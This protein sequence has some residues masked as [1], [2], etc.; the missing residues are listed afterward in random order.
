MSLL[1][2]VTMLAQP[3]ARTPEAEAAAKAAAD[4]AEKAKAEAKAKAATEATEKA[5]AEKAAA[6]KAAAEKADEAEKAKK[7]DEAEAAEKA[8]KADE[9]EK[10]KKADEAEK[11]ATEAEAKAAADEAEKAEKAKK[12]ATEA[13]AK[14]AADAAEKEAAEKA[15]AEA[16][17]AEAKA[18]AEKAAKAGEGLK[19]PEGLKNDGQTCYANSVIQLLRRM[20]GVGTK[21]D[22]DDPITET[23]MNGLVKSAL[24]TGTGGQQDAG[25]FFSGLVREEY[26]DSSFFQFTITQYKYEHVEVTFATIESTKPKIIPSESRTQKE[27]K[28]TCTEHENSLSAVANSYNNG[29]QVVTDLTPLLEGGYR[30]ED[31]DK[32][33]IGIIYISE[34]ARYIIVD[35]I[36]PWKH[37]T[38]TV[39]AS[40]AFEYEPNIKANGEILLKNTKHYNTVAVICFAG[41]APAKGDAENIA[42]IRARIEKQPQEDHAELWSAALR[43]NGHYV[44]YVKYGD[45]WYY[46]SDSTVTEQDG[47]LNILPGFIPVM[48]LLDSGA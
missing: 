13:E 9:A 25:E 24:D 3:P 28:I 45:K 17:E 22:F 8:K 1:M 6:E 39:D 21:F 40:V 46:T 27:D 4:A 38:F 15:K 7:A 19:K 10:A 26:I 16:A 31:D 44:C 14:A 29:L 36:N 2:L 41:S 11:A 32:V 12:A 20:P 30:I 18:A 35:I 37:K 43:S 34:M 33:L 48:I 23:Q 5:A 42:A 47:E